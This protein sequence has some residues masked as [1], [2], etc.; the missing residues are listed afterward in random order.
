MGSTVVFLWELNEIWHKWRSHTVLCLV[1]IDYCYY[2]LLSWPNFTFPSAVCYFLLLT[3]LALL[4]FLAWNLP[5]GFWSIQLFWFWSWTVVAGTCLYLFFTLAH[6]AQETTSADHC[7]PRPYL[8]ISALDGN[9]IRPGPPCVLCMSGQGRWEW[10]GVGTID[11][12]PFYTVNGFL[13]CFIKLRF[14]LH[15]IF[16]DTCIYSSKVGDSLCLLTL[17]CLL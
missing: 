14:S 6:L 2:W 13:M 15:R 3:L 9:H 1:S 5:C 16:V 8:Y 17:S 11:N 4:L 7:S 12:I 10:I